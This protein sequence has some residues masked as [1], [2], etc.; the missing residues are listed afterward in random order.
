M[1]H[2]LGLGI[3][4]AWSSFGASSG[5]PCLSSGSSWAPFHPYLVAY[6]GRATV[7]VLSCAPFSAE[8]GVVN[9]PEERLSFSFS[10]S[11]GAGGQNVNKV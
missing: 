4:A 2:R 7:H 11:S 8:G 9:I 6:R 1:I 10:R 3:G 5:L